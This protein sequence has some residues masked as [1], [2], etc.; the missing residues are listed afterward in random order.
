M[1]IFCL[2]GYFIRVERLSI[3]ADS[4]LFYLARASHSV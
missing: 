3:D 2:E 4:S 1:Q